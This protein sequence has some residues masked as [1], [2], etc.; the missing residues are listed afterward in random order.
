MEH[1]SDFLVLGSGIAGLLTALELSRRGSV[2]LLTKR[3]CS[4][5]NTA[6]AQGGI[7]AVMDPQDSVESH[8]RDTLL[9]GAGL[10]DEE[11]VRGV[12]AEGPDRIR[13]LIRLGVGFTG[14]PASPDLGLEGGHSHRR[15][16]HAGDG[17]GRE[18]VRALQAACAASPSIRL[19]EGLAAVDLILREHP[20]GAPP[21][22][23]RCLGAYALDEASGEVRAFAARATVLATGG[24]GKVYLYTSNPD[25]ATGDGMAMAYRAGL[26]LRNLEFVQFHPTCLYNP[27]ESA[28]E[29]RRFLLSE[30]LRGEG[31][32]LTLKGGRAFMRD[33]DPRAELAPRD[34]V[35]RAIDS[36]MKRTGAEC[37]YLDMTHKSADEL[38]RR[39]PNI[40][41]HC[42]RIGLD[43]ARE[44]IPVVPAAHFFCGGV[45][46]DAEGA[47]ELPGLYAV[48]E[49]AHTG[50]HGANRLASNSLLEGAVFAHRAAL[51]VA[52]DLERLPPPPALRPWD[53]GEA[54]PSD[55][56][57]VVGH[58]WHEIRRL[59]WDYVGIVRTDRR[60]QR[61]LERLR[62]ISAEVSDY[63]WRF[64]LTRD[65]IELRNIALLAEL[66][67]SC[68][69]A[70][71]ES[72]GLHF[73]A[74]HP[75]PLPEARDTAISRYASG[76]RTLGNQEAARI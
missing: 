36:E 28:E 16:L 73:N 12:V 51:R 63:Y 64:L 54:V 20:S 17:T 68:A 19:F 66:I 40:Y 52:S 1:R 61:A 74:D 60:L 34:V 4:Y 39:F 15:I 27:G 26:E 35:A 25:V 46:T 67:V 50:L 31:G 18:I 37:V 30:A 59:M 10:C 23:N 72:R 13:E 53:P 44:P 22:R 6:F 33:Y 38:Q 2:H 29:G 71:G 3:G 62:V 70:R 24:A 45:Q 75:R 32:R 65:L 58:D 7:A 69:L 76:R 5:S 8:V 56:A 21:S 43:M 41:A 11:I 57:V 49:T 42:R 9:A 55:E 14:L 48:G 47:T